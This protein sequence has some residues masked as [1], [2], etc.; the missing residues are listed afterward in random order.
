MPDVIDLATVQRKRLL[1]RERQT[2]L[3]IVNEYGRIYAT[4]RQRIDALALEISTLPDPTAQRV[5]R[6]ATYKALVSEAQSELARFGAWA[7][8]EIVSAASVAARD[9]ESD[10]EALALVVFPLAL[11]GRI[12]WR[13][14]PADAILA[15]LPY[16]A[17]TSPIHAALVQEFAPTLIDDLE[18]TIANDVTLRRNIGLAVRAALGAGLTW[19]LR[20]ART[21]SVK[22]YNAAI[23]A[24]YR[25]NPDVVTGWVW[26]AT[27]DPNCC[28]S[29]VA[30]HGTEHSPS[31]TLDDHHNG[32]CVALPIVRGR[33]PEGSEQTGREW[34]D[35]L[36]DAEQQGIMG[37]AK[38]RAWRDGAVAWEDMTG[39]TSD[40]ALGSMRYAPSLKA[41]LGDDAGQ[42]YNWWR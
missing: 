41:L 6:L 37:K 17:V 42:Y 1:Q 35:A 36:T 13:R 38:W 32:R 16:M 39:I 40:P 2:A 34:F 28:I 20:T 3:R 21:L 5:K 8:T 33:R 9:G 15:T 11:R 24:N 22:A 30:M 25:G 27:L 10:A 14:I 19:V 23:G 26:W 12:P 7:D 31:E 4:L 18:D 29:C